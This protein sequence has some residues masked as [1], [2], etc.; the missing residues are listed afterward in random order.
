MNLTLKEI[1]KIIES[2]K[3][4]RQQRT[5]KNLFTKEEI[6]G[7]IEKYNEH[8]INGFGLL[9]DEASK[10]N[11][12]STLFNGAAFHLSYTYREEHTSSWLTW[13]LKMDIIPEKYKSEIF[14]YIFSNLVPHEKQNNKSIEFK[15]EKG[16]KFENEKLIK[17][18]DQDEKRSIIGRL[19]VFIEAPKFIIVIENKIGDK[20]L[21]KNIYY[22][23][24]IDDQYKNKDI[25]I[26]ILLIP[27]D[28]LRIFEDNDDINT[29][30]KKKIIE[31]FTPITWE[32]MLLTL[33]DTID[34]LKCKIEKERKFLY[35]K[36]LVLAF[37]SFIEGNVLDFNI[38]RINEGLKKDKITKPEIREIKR[39]LNYRGIGRENNG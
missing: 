9:R 2:Y 39:Y 3:M 17:Y 16:I 25:I 12:E 19:D 30:E 34:E 26:C 4:S 36:I 32:K 37:I 24:K 22:R 29:E 10:I 6:N 18:F 31:A 20:K 13:I 23:E 27:A 11:M 21:K 33:Y 1:N 15:D 5:R 35:W 28:D 8:L 38:S 7:I 14:S